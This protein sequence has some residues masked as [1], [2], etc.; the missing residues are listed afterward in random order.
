MSHEAAGIG[1]PP[2]STSVRATRWIHRSGRTRP[3]HD[4]R[5]PQ[6]PAVAVEVGVS[7]LS[8]LFAYL[9]RVGMVGLVPDMARAHT[10]DCLRT[11][12]RR[13][14]RIARDQRDAVREPAQL[15]V[16]VAVADV[17]G[18][19]VDVPMARHS[20]AAAAICRRSSPQRQP[21]STTVPR[22]ADLP[23]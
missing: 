5:V 23:K 3:P 17:A 8:R 2:T 22:R 15:R 16:L 1:T 18:V 9:V 4:K 13:D 11:L 20:A 7:L 12:R 10:D 19:E 14:R 21:I 6:D